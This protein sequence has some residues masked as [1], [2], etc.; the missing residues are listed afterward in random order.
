MPESEVYEPVLVY[1]TAPAI[2]LG[3]QP[4]LVLDA[5]NRG[6]KLDELSREGLVLMTHV[7]LLG[8]N[9]ESSVTQNKL[10]NYVAVV[11]KAL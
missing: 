5:L 4:V 9:T 3:Q 6:S 2:S 7:G 8:Q 11:A 1:D 10:L